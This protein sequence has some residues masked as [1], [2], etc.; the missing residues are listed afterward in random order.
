MEEYMPEI[1]REYLQLMMLKVVLVSFFSYFNIFYN[2]KM[3]HFSFWKK[4]GSMGAKMV[5]KEWMEGGDDQ[6]REI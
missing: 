2:V 1:S 4:G 6:K 3:V 5:G